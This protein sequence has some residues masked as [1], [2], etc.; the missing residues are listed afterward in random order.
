VLRSVNGK[1][2]QGAAYVF[3]RDPSIGWVSE[4]KLTASDGTTGDF[5]GASV[6]ISDQTAVVGATFADYPSSVNQGAAYVFVR[7]GGWFEQARLTAQGGENFD[8]FGSSVAIAGDTVM[9]GANQ[10]NVGNNSS[11]GTAHV[12]GRAGRTW[13]ELA[14]ITATDGAQGEGFGSSVAISGDTAIVGLINGVVNAGITQGTAWILDLNVNDLSSASNDVSNSS[15]ASLNAA[16]LPASS[17]QQI[18]ATEGAWRSV[19]TL[20]T[21]GRSLKLRSGGDVRTTPGSV[22]TLGGSSSL[23]AA[24]L[25]VAEIFGQLRVSS[26]ASADVSADAFTLGSRG[27]LTARTGSSL[28]INA[29]NVQ[30]EGQTRLEQGSSLT[31]AGTVTAIG[32]TTANLNTSLTSDGTFTNIDIF[33]INS[34]TVSSPLFWNRAQTNIFGT[35]AFYGSY[36]ND[37]S[38]T[39]L[40]R[41]G[42]L[43]VFG[44]LVN[45]GTIVGALCAGCLGSPPSLDVAGTLSIGAASSLLLP[46]ADATVHVGSD[47]DCAVDGNTRYDMS[48]ATL[49]L[50]SISGPDAIQDL[51]AMSVDVGPIATGLDRTISGHYPIKTL[52]IGPAPST[53]QVVDA[54]DNDGL[55][56]G[57]CEAIY[58]DQLRIDA[59]SRL[60]NTS[61]RIYY[62]TLINSGVIDVPSNVI[63]IGQVCAADF[64]GDGFLTFED[65]DAFVGAFESGNASADF[66]GDGFLSFEDFDAFVLAFEAGC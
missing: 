2:F 16:V 42:T 9:V 19:N 29:P 49:Q 59:G 31:L 52:R 12:F 45:D 4:F 22:L 10:D 55:G 21:V 6:A 34:G 3:F 56:Q 38:A 61:C 7:S 13:S 44:S 17:G 26:G 18:T 30:L 27:I 47:F 25:S 48:L 28:T 37:V 66:N 8:G 51:E 1:P 54:W 63:K 50:E 5:F 24:D 43:F 36:S 33:T 58:V 60:I 14:T 64:N 46:F 41:S 23:V 15:F 39:T 62:N 40:I 57:S 35:S 11:Q 53:A 20:D 65:F 32:P